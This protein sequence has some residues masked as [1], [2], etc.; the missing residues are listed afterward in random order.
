[1]EVVTRDDLVIVLHADHE[2]ASA[3]MTLAEAAERLSWAMREAG[4]GTRSE[5]E[6]AL[7]AAHADPGKLRIAMTLPSNEAVLGAV[8]AGRCAAALSSAVVRPFV[9][10]GQLRIL[11]IALPPRNFT[12]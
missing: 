1:M 5:F 12:I 4:S 2:M 6:A 10:A 3:G 7:L 8:R 11:D 9:E